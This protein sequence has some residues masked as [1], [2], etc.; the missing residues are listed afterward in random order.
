M[1][2]QLILKN[3]SVE[4]KRPTSAQLAIGEISLNYNQEGAFLCCEDSAGNIQQIGGVKIDETAPSTPVK[5]SLWFKPSTLVL[6]IYDG[7]N[8]QAVGNATVA[9]VNG[10]TGAV[11]LTAADV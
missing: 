5:Q 10:Q 4:D 7:S 3:S 1:A 8:W 6:S 2:V 11:V 9:S